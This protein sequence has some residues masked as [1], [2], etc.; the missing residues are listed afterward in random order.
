MFGNTPN[1]HQK[2]T[3]VLT[4]AG[5]YLTYIIMCERE[6]VPNYVK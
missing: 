2:Y 1:D 3:R 5:K 6:A 4:H